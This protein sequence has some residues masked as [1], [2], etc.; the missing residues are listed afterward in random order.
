MSD[1]SN[2]TNLLI[3][4][5]AVWRDD[6]GAA[7]DKVDEIIRALQ[8]VSARLRLRAAESE[9][10]NTIS[11]RS[12]MSDRVQIKVIGSDGAIKQTADTGG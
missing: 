9:S 2:L 6:P 3:E 5:L 10:K 11:S 1:K 7:A 8:V 12:Q 4:S